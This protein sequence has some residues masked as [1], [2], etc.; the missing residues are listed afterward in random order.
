MYSTFA[1]QYVKWYTHELDM[2]QIDQYEEFERQII[3]ATGWEK[4][5]VISVD[6][7]HKSVELLNYLIDISSETILTENKGNSVLIQEDIHGRL[8]RF[9]D[10]HRQWKE[11]RGFFL[12]F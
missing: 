5:F 9:P 10:F 7:N 1:D 2:A 4:W 11:W 3:L 6:F 12:H 8:Y